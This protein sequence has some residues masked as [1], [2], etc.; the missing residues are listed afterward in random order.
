MPLQNCTIYHPSFSS[1]YWGLFLGNLD[2]LKRFK[3]INKLK[4]DEL[5][6]EVQKFKELIIEATFL[7]RTV[8]FLLFGYL[9]ET[10]EILNTRTLVWAFGIIAAI[11][12]IRAAQFRLSRIPMFPM[13]FI[14]PRG[15]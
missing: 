2:E 5:N 12:I 9:I 13:L 7:V 14:A 10:K 1:L 15:D 4:P 11:L 6:L 8:F 3:W